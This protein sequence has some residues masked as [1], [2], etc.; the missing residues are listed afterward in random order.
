MPSTLANHPKRLMKLKYICTVIAVVV[1][2]AASILTIYEQ[3]L[4]DRKTGI[5]GTSYVYKHMTD[6]GKAKHGE[7]KSA[8]KI[9]IATENREEVKS[10]LTKLSEFYTAEAGKIKDGRTRKA[11]SSLSSDCES[12]MKKI[13]SDKN[14]SLSGIKPDEITA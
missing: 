13:T 2:A 9:A 4:P 8:L 5:W 14:Y 10:L 3:N 6:A 11:L 7:L 12:L 1:V